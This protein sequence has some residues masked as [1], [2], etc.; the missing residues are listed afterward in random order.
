MK[1][2]WTESWKNYHNNMAKFKELFPENEAI[3]INLLTKIETYADS[4][5][6]RSGKALEIAGEGNID[7]ATGFVFTTAYPTVLQWIQTTQDLVKHEN[8]ITLIRFAEVESLYT[9]RRTTML[10]LGALA[11]VLSVLIVIL[12][13]LG[14]TRPLYLSVQVAER[15]ASGDLTIN[16][17][18]M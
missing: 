10:I 16:L 2:K 9:V 7:E 8:E 18:S 1:D 5:E 12:L 4:A 15:I 11:I 6:Q 14:I 17:T 3:R 13:T